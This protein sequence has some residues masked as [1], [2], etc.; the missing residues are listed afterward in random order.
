M[1]NINFNNNLL[2]ISNAGLVSVGSGTPSDVS[3]AGDL[4]VGDELEVVNNVYCYGDYQQEEA[5]GAALNIK[6]IAEEVTISVGQGSGG[7]ATSGNLAPADSLILA[8]TARVTD[9]PGGGATTFD[10]GVTGSGNLDSLIDGVATAL[11]TQGNSASD[12]DGTQLPIAN[13]TAT[14]L[15]V[16]TDSD[17]TDNEMKIRLVVWYLELV[18]P[19]S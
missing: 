2:K 3:G 12:N 13:G 1:G 16:T 10:V 19:T 11:D 6:S 7:V 18:E 17:V 9:A 14:T 5:N 4:Y 15:T 8:V